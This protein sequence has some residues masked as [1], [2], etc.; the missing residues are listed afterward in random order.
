MDGDNARKEDHELHRKSQDYSNMA[1]APHRKIHTTLKK[2]GLVYARHSK[3]I[4]ASPSFILHISFSFSGVIKELKE[5]SEVQNLKLHS[6]MHGTL[7]L[8]HF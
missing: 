5:S 8:P 7:E 6:T 1:I 3:T 4:E 2:I